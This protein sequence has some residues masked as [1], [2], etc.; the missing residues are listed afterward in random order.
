MARDSATQPAADSADSVDAVAS[1]V[2]SPDSAD[3]ATQPASPVGHAADSADSVDSAASSV[4]SPLDSVSA[5]AHAV[6]TGSVAQKKVVANIAVAVRTG[7]VRPG[8]TIA[9]WLLQC[10]VGHLRLAT[11]QLIK[12]FASSEDPF[13]NGP[14]Y[15]NT[16][17]NTAVVATRHFQENI[18]LAPY[19]E[20]EPDD[21]QASQK[22]D[23]SAHF[24]RCG[25]N[26]FSSRI[27]LTFLLTG[28]G[29][30]YERG[31][32]EQLDQVLLLHKHCIVDQET[33]QAAHNVL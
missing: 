3:S 14:C 31:S 2:H 15:E 1:S 9:S 32:V 13:P 23:H 17:Q 18:D 22:I 5:P 30:G 19:K 33:A 26:K 4:H 6:H 10:H 21:L 16:S 7:L 28:A 11:F 12:C 27:D 29:S 25:L 20:T 24:P 8:G